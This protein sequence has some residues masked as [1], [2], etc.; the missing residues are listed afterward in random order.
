MGKETPFLRWKNAKDDAKM[1]SQSGIR[2]CFPLFL[3]YSN[4]YLIITTSQ[5]GLL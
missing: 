3:L 1:P 2:D 4:E 5:M